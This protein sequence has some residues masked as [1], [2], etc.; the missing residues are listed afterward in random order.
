MELLQ[1]KKNFFSFDG[2]YGTTSSEVTFSLFLLGSAG[3]PSTC[4][5]YYSYPRRPPSAPTSATVPL[6]ASPLTKACNRL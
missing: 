6:S 3:S 2:I 4:S 1:V 5:T